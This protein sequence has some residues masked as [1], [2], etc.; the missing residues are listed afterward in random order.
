MKRTETIA[1]IGILLL[2]TMAMAKGSPRIGYL[3]EKI[4]SA[5]TVETQLHSQYEAVKAAYNSAK[6]RTRSLKR[7]RKA[8]DK[9]EQREYKAARARQAAANREISRYMSGDMTAPTQVRWR[10]R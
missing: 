6:A 3:D 10:T 9:R 2:S 7:E 8:V 4:R 1:A 5:Y